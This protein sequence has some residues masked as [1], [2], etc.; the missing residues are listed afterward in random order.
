MHS[1]C[2]CCF[3]FFPP[4][5]FAIWRQPSRLGPREP[6]GVYNHGEAKWPGSSEDLNMSCLCFPEAIKLLVR[7]SFV[8]PEIRPGSH[9]KQPRRRRL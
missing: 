7:V 5:V 1:A 2:I 8:T 4:H 6:K 9:H 3:T